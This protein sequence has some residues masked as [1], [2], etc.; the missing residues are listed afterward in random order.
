ML[1]IAVAKYA[2]KVSQQVKHQVAEKKSPN[3]RNRN[4]KNG[5]QEDDSTA[6]LIIMI[7]AIAMRPRTTIIAI[8][9]K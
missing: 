8:I 9:P 1:V 3:T 4:M 6:M 7:I 5:R 2:P